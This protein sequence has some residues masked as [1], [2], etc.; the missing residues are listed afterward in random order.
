MHALRVL[1]FEAIRQRLQSHCE[2]PVGA[3]LAA[4]LEPSYDADEVWELLHLTREAMDFIARQPAPSLG[5]LRDPRQAFDRASKGAVLSGAEIF[6][7]A[8]SLYVMRTLKDAVKP[9][10][11]DYGRL[12]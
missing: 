1:E 7:A 8:D 2:T 9:G 12:W 6:Q 10:R 11:A 4:E 5:G 3:A